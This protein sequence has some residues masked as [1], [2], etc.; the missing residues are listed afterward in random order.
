MAIQQPAITDFQSSPDHSLSH[1]V[2]ANDNAA[3]VKSVVADSA[4]RIGVG[5]D[6]PTANLHIKAGGTAASSAPFKLT[7]QA[8][9]LTVV[10]QGAMELVGNSL[11]FTQ[12]AKRRGVAMTQS[13]LTADV[14]VGNSTTESAALITAEHGAGYLEVG[15]CEEIILRGTIQQTAAGG[16]VV[17]IRVKY[18]GATI[19]TTTTA[20]GNI[21][22]GTPFEI[23]VTT[24]IRTIGATG[25]MQINSVLWIDGVTNVPDSATLVNNIDTTTA[26]N[27][28]ITAQWTVQ[29]ASNTMTVN[30]GRVLCIEPNR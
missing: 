13:P 26:Q 9:G 6:T 24:T 22:A 3:P 7:T 30:Q 2:F 5:T 21:A 29:N 20:A 14:T 8:N 4:G 1:R 23:R 28:T 16:G 19:Q 15:K 25:S 10:E 18:A 12:L 11:Q 17:Q 27:T